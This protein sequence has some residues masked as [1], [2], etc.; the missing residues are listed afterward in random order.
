MAPKTTTLGASGPTVNALGIGL[1]SLGHAYG[2]AGDDETRLA[3]LDKLWEM[4]ETFWDDADIYGDSEELVGKWFTLHPER[5]KDIFLA[6]KF[7][8]VSVDPTKA[9]EIRSDPEYIREALEKSLKKLKTDYVDLYYCHRVDEKTPIEHTVKAMADLKQSVFLC[10]FHKFMLI[11]VQ[12]RQDPPHRPL[13]DRTQRPPPRL[14][15]PPHRCC[16]DRIQSLGS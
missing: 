16:R 15:G 2:D 1:M 10:Y 5:R 3:F 9:M 13:R 14:Q 7:G 4:G 12:T 6:T 11:S 8:F